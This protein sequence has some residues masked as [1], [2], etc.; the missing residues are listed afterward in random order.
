MLIFGELPEVINFPKLY[1][2]MFWVYMHIGGL[3]GFMIG[4]VTG[5]QIQ[6]T[7]P[8][9][10]NISGTAKACAQ[11]VIACIYFHEIKSYLWWT[12]NAVVLGGSG[13]Y[14]EVK[15]S[16]MKQQH[17]ED[18]TK[19]AQKIDNVDTAEKGAKQPLQ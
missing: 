13:A 9:T 7:S 11:T 15:R 14:T 17:N 10:H 8:L 16:E 18:I 4:Y 3:F 2:P 5:L 1:D 6:I 19:L 12:S